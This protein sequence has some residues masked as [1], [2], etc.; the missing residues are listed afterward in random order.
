[1]GEL[2]LEEPN[3]S[4]DGNIEMDEAAE[5]VS[6]MDEVASLPQLGVDETVWMVS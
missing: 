2:V 4:M 5:W 3:D 6:D 1:M